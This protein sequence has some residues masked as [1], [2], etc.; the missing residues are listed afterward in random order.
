MHRITVRDGQEELSNGIS[1][2]F[3]TA[4]CPACAGVFSVADEYTAA[5]RPLMR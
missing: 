1:H 3:G 2:L 5:N 4:E